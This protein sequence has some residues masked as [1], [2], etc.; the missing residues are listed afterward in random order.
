MRTP[1]VRFGSFAIILISVYFVRFV[2]IADIPPIMAPNMCSGSVAA[3]RP[4]A[5]LKSV[6]VE[7]ATNSRNAISKDGTPYR[8]ET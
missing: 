3:Q 2:P 7:K 5:A 6:A 8:V 1:D 4:A